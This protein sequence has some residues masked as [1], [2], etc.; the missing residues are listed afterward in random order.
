MRLHMLTAA[1][2][3]STLAPA[4]LAAQH[5]GHGAHGDTA[6]AA[7][8]A[9]GQRVMGVDQY[10]STHRVEALADG[11]RLELRRDVDD[12]VGTETIRTHLRE[13]VRRLGAGDFSLSVA[14]HDKEI[15]GARVLAARRALVRYSFRELPRG[16]EV[17]IL[18]TDPDAV[19]AVHEF[20][21]FQAKEHR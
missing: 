7:M 4:V 18:T 6:H 2:A 1:L 13:V 21:A 20:L 3:A 15:P 12:S 17:R 5:A 11:G 8:Q 14:V 19:R 10:T 9:R 16:G